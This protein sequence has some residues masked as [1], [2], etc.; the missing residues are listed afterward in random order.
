MLQMTRRRAWKAIGIAG[1]L[2]RLAAEPDRSQPVSAKHALDDLLAGNARFKA[3]QPLHPRRRPED[4]R[5]TAAAQFPQAVIITCSDS[6]V[7]PEVLFDVGVGDVFIIRIAG[8]II[9]GA[10]VTI[11]GSI[12]Y[13]VAELNVPLIMVLGHSNCGAVKSAVQHLNDNDALPGSINGLVNLVKPA[14]AASKNQPGDALSNAIRQNVILGVNF[15]NDFGPI[16]APKVKS[17]S[18]KIVGG[19]YDLQTGSVALV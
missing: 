4:F 8:N 16:I 14:V 13:A 10:G 3:G 2:T 1:A 19:V 6:R 15:L 9:A 18:V 7:A 17:G 12:E 5:A 11:K